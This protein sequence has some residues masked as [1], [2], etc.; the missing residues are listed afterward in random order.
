MG[1]RMTFRIKHL[2]AVLAI[3]LGLH[4]AARPAAAGDYN[5]D[6]MVRLGASVVHPDESVSAYA[7]GALI[8]GASADIS[9]QVIPSATLT[10]FL[11]KN[12]ALELFCCFTKHSVE[13]RGTA[14]NG[15]DLGDA[16]LFPPAVTVQYHFDSFGQFKPYVGAGVQYIAFFNEGNSDLGGKLS[17]DNAFGFTLQAGV[18]M[19]IGGGWYLNADVKK[20]WLDTEARWENTGITADVDLDPWIF[21][22]N[23]GYRFNLFGPRNTGYEPMK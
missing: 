19:E 10:Y 23:I 11:N 15:L 12:I 17:V 1:E 21:S 7:G 9:T 16:W 2:V 22:A 13:G 3:A 4:G 5:G 6:F 20:T 18:D 14:V 8:P